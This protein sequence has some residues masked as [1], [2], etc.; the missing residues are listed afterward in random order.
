MNKHATDNR[1]NQLNPNNSAYVSSRGAQGVSGST[2]DTK[3][4]EPTKEGGPQ[5]S[6]PNVVE[7]K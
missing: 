7:K 1:A 3:Q 4:N 6:R 5:E 2:G